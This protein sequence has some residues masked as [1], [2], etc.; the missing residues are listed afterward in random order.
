MPMSE[1]E[2]RG[3]PGEEPEEGDEAEEEAVE[4][5]SQPQSPLVKILILGVSVLLLVG[6]A[7]FLT[8]R[9]ILPRL[10]NTAVGETMT[11]VKEKMKKP[12]K[13]KEKKKGPVIRHPITGITA[14][15]AGSLGRRFVAFDLEVQTTYEDA[16]EEMVEKDSEIRNALIFYFSGRTVREI[17]TR[18]FQVAAR[19]TVR[20]LI[21]GVV[22]GEPV[23]TVFFTTFLI[24]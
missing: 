20:S 15:T 10:P 6:G 19:D 14:N 23:D 21:N 16:V 18:E 11:G 13:E 8:T 5:E 1:I 7:Y 12:K 3:A 9:I 17:A 2:D 4:K 22:E 24:Q